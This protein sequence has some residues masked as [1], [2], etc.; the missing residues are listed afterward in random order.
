M[1]GSESIYWA[2]A[3]DELDAERNKSTLTPHIFF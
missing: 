3:T 1:M 2:F